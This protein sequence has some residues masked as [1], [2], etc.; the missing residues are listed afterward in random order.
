MYAATILSSNENHTGAK[1][2]LRR[3]GALM[4]SERDIRYLMP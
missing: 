2:I 4:A 1:V 3:C